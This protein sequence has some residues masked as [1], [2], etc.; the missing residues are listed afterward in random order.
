[1]SP[2]IKKP[3]EKTIVDAYSIKAPLYEWLMSKN[4]KRGDKSKVVNEALELL[5]TQEDKKAS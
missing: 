2:P 3:E 5:K 1:M 4:F